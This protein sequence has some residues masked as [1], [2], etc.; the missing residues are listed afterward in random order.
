MEVSMRK[1][2]LLVALLLIIPACMPTTAPAPESLPV[3]VA[4][5]AS[6]GQISSGNSATLRWNV[7]GATN[8]QI[9]QGIGTVGLAGT[10]SVAPGTST[11][12]TLTA[13]NSVGVANQSITVSVTSMPSPA[14]SP[15]PTPTP[16]PP[17]PAGAPPVVIL[18][19]I[20][21]NVVDKS[22]GQKATIR[23]DVN[24][25]V[26]VVIQPGFGEVQHQGTKIVNPPALGVHTYTLITSNGAGT[27]TRT[28]TLTVKP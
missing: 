24:N 9:D 12:Y 6:P 16:T 4:F 28:Q 20:S 1:V 17:P 14:P 18:F 21:P 27:I 3:I 15:S 2:W 10:Q 22:M 26:Q 5:N 13:S 25:A 8:V 19:D 11:T 7:T 23:W